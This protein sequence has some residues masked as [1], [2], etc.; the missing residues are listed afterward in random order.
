MNL[1][2]T[3]IILA[4][5]LVT[6]EGEVAPSAQA[7]STAAPAPAG[8]EATSP[9]A[10]YLAKG[11]ANACGPGCSQWIVA[12]GR[13][14]TGAAERLRRLLAKLGHAKPPIFFHSPGGLI[15]EGLEIGR[16]IREQ[17]LEASVAHTVP[18]ACLGDKAASK[19]CEAQKVSGQAVEAIFDPLI[20]MCNSSCVHALAGGIVRLV[21]PGVKLGIHDVGFDPAHAEQPKAVLAQSKRLAHERIEEYLHDMGIDQGL[22]RAALAVP[23]ESKRFLDRD[24]LVRFGIDRR[25][26]GEAPWELVEKP[27][28]FL[29]KRFFART[30]ND[31]ARYIEGFVAFN[32]GTFGEVRLTL[33]RR[34][35]AAVANADISAELSVN[36]SEQ[37][38]DLGYRTSTQEYDLSSSSLRLATVALLADNGVTLRLSGTDLARA[39]DAKGITLDMHGFSDPLDKLR[40]SCDAVANAMTGASLPASFPNR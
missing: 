21:P 16:T 19:S 10:F 13:I 5:L 24:E 28:P 15:S 30:G 25:E 17:K 34:Q 9:I 2:P 8:V 11:D 29:V 22:Y 6:V 39:D 40:K 12:E 27:A 18:I 36:V 37:R 7:A 14:N 35:N 3:A 26:F 23:Y 38:I 31:Q 4:T 32:C 33:G 20:A 1:R